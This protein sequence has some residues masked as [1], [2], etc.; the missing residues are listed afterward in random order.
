VQCW[1]RWS[2]RVSSSNA[3]RGTFT[4][5]VTTISKSSIFLHIIL[6]ES[7]QFLT[8]WAKRVFTFTTLW[9]AFSSME[10]LSSLGV[11]NTEMPLWNKLHCTLR[12]SQGPSHGKR[13]KLTFV[14]YYPFPDNKHV[15]AC[16]WES[17]FTFVTK[18]SIPILH[19]FYWSFLS[20]VCVRRFGATLQN[21][22]ATRIPQPQVC[23][24]SAHI[25]A[26]IY[27]NTN[28]NPITL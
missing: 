3:L 6:Q 14:L 26:F 22:A 1:Q 5:S 2:L 17:R 7:V 11:L 4:I 16:I 20:F 15:C 8:F 19:C 24:F 23:D 13:I 12:A 28:Q 18:R 10:A 25:D 27:S 9:S 21:Q